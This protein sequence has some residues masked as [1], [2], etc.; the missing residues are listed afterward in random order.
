MLNDLRTAIRTL[1]RRPFYPIAEV[2]ILALGLTAAIAVFTYIN[3]F[4]QPFP[5][6][7]AD[8]LVRVFG[9]ETDDLY[10]N[11]SYLDY[12]DYAEAE[13]SFSGVAAAQAGYAASVR[14]ENL[15]EV[16]FLEAV[17]GDYFSVLDIDVH[18]GRGVHA[19]D[20]Q[21]G[22]D[23]V[24]VISYDWWQRSFNADSTVIGNT[25][26]LNFRPF[27]LV[28]VMSPEFLGSTSG[29][30]PDVWIP[31]APFA[32]RYVSWTRA[33]ENRDLPLIRVYA[34]LRDG[35]SIEQGSAELAAVARGLDEQYPR[36]E[37]V[38]QIRLDPAT[39]IDPQTR[40]G[41]A[42]TLQLMTA[43]AIGLLLL[44]SANVANLLLSVALG[45]QREVA[46]RA[47]LG[48]SRV[49][50]VR[51]ALIENLILASAAGGIAL[52]LAGPV[53]RR[54]GSYFAR[55]SVWG[56]NVTRVVSV[57]LRVVVFAIVVSIVI[58]LAAGLFPALRA[59]RANLAA[60]LGAGA[61]SV[62]SPRQILGLRLPGAQDLLVTAQVA[63]SI[64]LLV[65]AGL[66][67]RTFA[68]VGRLDPGFAYENL[69][70]THVSTSSTT[71]EP[72]EREG[73][74]R[75]LAERVADE[76]WV[77]TATVVDYPLLSPH[78]TMEFRIDGLDE[79]GPMAYSR[80]IPGFFEALGIDVVQGRAFSPGDTL[81]ARDVAMV[82]ES[83]VRRHL[84][85]D[86]AIGRAIWWPGA[87]DDG[88]RA[89]EI[90]GVVRDTKTRDYFAEPEPTVYF[91]YPQHP[92]PTGSALIVAT[93]GDPRGLVPDLNQWLRNF[94]PYLAIVNVV[95]YTDVVRGYQYTQRM[96]AEL[97][98]VMAF[99][100]VALAAV[101]IFSVLNLAVTRRTK[102]I[103]I[104]ISVGAATRDIGRMVV[105]R[106]MKP[107]L[108][109]L[110]VG[111][112]A[113]FAV[114]RL[115]RSLL[116]GVDP[117]DPMTLVVGTAVLLGIAVVAAYVPAHRATTVD[118]VTAL[119]QE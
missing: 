92:Y 2:G 99:L 117:N 115:V 13:G 51:M 84:G 71:L 116:F 56:E 38:R 118:P 8:G 48:A 15:T 34:R 89:F 63:L 78:P 11:I 107:V 97:F 32:D 100:G 68:S 88:D 76:P 25:L 16:A 30:R 72:E 113:S 24:A 75:D 70:V 83:F 82:N 62:G 6:A 74:F 61:G 10:Q 90:V 53:T 91:S 3:G 81:V 111:L 42:P 112:A 85:G 19:G 93:N 14:R 12:L 44:V 57:D 96:N 94:E 108:L 65:V 54:L 18:I 41:E 67:A 5:G 95:A 21:L 98:S 20:D 69:I 35:S 110:G 31:I 9:V 37:A 28:G 59:S 86:N 114:T 36:Q 4:S 87:M 49:R 55:P 60:M 106:A 1:R 80:L 66:V 22:T 47:A 39:W 33:A 64:V 102:E 27:T 104:R 79:P 101:G 23:A 17:S 58:G 52:A 43:A 50:L 109:G 7:D 105:S 119:R 73:F 77:R 45:R 46:M 29:F 103:G 26:Y 40:L